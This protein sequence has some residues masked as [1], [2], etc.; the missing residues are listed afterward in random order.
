V[1]DGGDN[2]LAT[3]YGTRSAGTREEFIWDPKFKKWISNK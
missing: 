1:I 3:T 2:I